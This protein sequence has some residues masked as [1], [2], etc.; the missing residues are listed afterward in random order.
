MYLVNLDLY[1]FGGLEN[2]EHLRFC[3]PRASFKDGG[4]IFSLKLKRSVKLEDLFK[5]EILPLKGDCNRLE[6]GFVLHFIMSPKC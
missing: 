1:V 3:Q 6:P 5:I 4:K 2:T